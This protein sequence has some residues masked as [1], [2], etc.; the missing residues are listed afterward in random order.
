MRNESYLQ[1]RKKQGSGSGNFISHITMII[2]PWILKTSVKVIASQYCRILPSDPRVCGPGEA[3]L[4][5]VY[6]CICVGSLWTDKCLYIVLKYACPHLGTLLWCF[7]YKAISLHG[8][9]RQWW[10]IS[11]PAM[12]ICIYYLDILGKYMHVNLWQLVGG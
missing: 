1:W 4:L 11:E 3:L 10:A 6:I 9:S 5:F 2:H 8:I 12:T 7:P